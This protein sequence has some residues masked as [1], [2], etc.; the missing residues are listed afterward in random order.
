MR[1]STFPLAKK[2]HRLW[3]AG[4]RFR[5]SF[6][7]F[8]SRL[9]F[10]DINHDHDFCIPQKFLSSFSLVRPPFILPLSSRFPYRIFFDH[11]GWYNNFTCYHQ[12]IRAKTWC[13][14]LAWKRTTPTI[15]PAG[16]NAFKILLGNISPTKS[17]V[18]ICI[19]SG[20][21][22]FVYSLHI[23]FSLRDCIVLFDTYTHTDFVC[24]L[25]FYVL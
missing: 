14:K 23:I 19:H 8:V 20:V 15:G 17:C 5:R 24:V 11:R 22:F 21:R 10:N 6:S 1:L 13:S 25:K 2:T 9:S 3:V 18:K 7:R 12:R 4:S 16:G